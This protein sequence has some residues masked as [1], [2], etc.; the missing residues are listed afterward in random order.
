M[1]WG[2]PLQ[3]GCR[4][5]NATSIGPTLA[6]VQSM[7]FTEASAAR[8]ALLSAAYCIGLGVP[9][10]VI[11][12]TLRRATAALS[13]LRRH[14]IAIMRLGGIT[15]IGLGLLLLTGYWDTISIQMRVWTSNFQAPF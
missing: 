10:I 6:A 3:A 11:G 7:A 2:L 15:M 4:S 14:T 12:L 8:G 13:F 5:P 1:S 9:F